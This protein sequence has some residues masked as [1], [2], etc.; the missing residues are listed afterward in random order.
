MSSMKTMFALVVL[1]SAGVAGCHSKKPATAPP[2]AEKA[3]E[4][5][6]MGGAAYGGQK[7]DAPKPD[8]PKPDAPK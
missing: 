8:A 4:G 3:P 2:A 7:A 1:S 5:G 6:A